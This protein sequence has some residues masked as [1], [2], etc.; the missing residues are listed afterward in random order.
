M[1]KRRVFVAYH[2]N[3]DQKAVEEF[4]RHFSEDLEVFTD[5]SLERAADS[6]EVDY[7]TQVCREAIQ[8]TSVTIVLVGRQ[9]GGRKFVDWEIHYT[10][11]REHGLL[12][13]IVPGLDSKEAWVPD[14][15]QDN[16]PSGSGYAEWYEYPSSASELKAII[17][18]AY[19][20]DKSLIDNSRPRRQHNSR[21]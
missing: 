20:A 12:G 3:G 5:S 10:L 19:D 6:E 13:I 17:D 9:T 7:L 1:A 11:R 2:H 18:E 8:G 15:L 16:R 4:R 21:R 14:R